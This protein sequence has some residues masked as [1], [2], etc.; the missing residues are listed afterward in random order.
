MRNDMYV[1][2][3]N[4][5]RR[6][7]RKKNNSGLAALVAVTAILGVTVAIVLLVS[8]F[9]GTPTDKALPNTS[10]TGAS[11][12][13]ET[14]L[15]LTV[16]P[17]PVESMAISQNP[18]L[19][20]GTAQI[21][22]PMGTP[23]EGLS[24]ADW[25]M[26]QSIFFGDSEVSPYV[27]KDPVFFGDPVDYQSVPGILTYRGNNFR[28]CASWGVFPSNPTT[29]EQVWEFTG[30]GTLPVPLRAAAGVELLGRDRH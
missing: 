25:K 20:P 11:G 26:T 24:P 1:R 8:V 15:I 5:F 23:G 12:S 10:V 21:N 22:V 16:T 3:D 9:Q 27:R 28:N 4:S 18:N 6:K 7:K 14:V 17:T 30:I 2:Y 19:Y 29:L 13:D